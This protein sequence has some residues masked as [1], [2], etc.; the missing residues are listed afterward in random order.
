M[1]STLSR[2]TPS[3]STALHVTLWL[4]QLLLALAFGMAG[5][6]KS[7]QPVAELAVAMSWTGDVPAGLVRFIGASELAAALGLVLPAATRIRPLLTPLAA[8][9]LAIV[10][11]LAS[12]F[13]ISRGEWFALPLN[14][15]LGSLAA[16][17][18]WGRLR[19]VPIFP[20]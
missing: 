12:L 20:R 18:A 13:H 19:K 1:A 7:T 6:M 5:I 3:G 17:V 8:I 10:M 9:G 15:V 2:V 16:F 14:L 11:V 4:A